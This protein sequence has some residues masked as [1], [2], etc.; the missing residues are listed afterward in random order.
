MSDLQ[1]FID[2]FRNKRVFVI[3]D[4]IIDH[5]IHG[6]VS[7]ISPD[8]PVPLVE[9]SREEHF[10][11]AL[12]KVIQY[13]LNFGGD[14]EAISCVG[15]DYEGEKFQQEIAELN[16]GIKG[17]FTLGQITPKITRVMSK[18][19][20]L[21]RLE[22][23]YNFTHQEENVLGESIVNF[24]KERAGRA[25]VILILDYDLGLLDPPIIEKVLNIAN[26][27]KKKI[28]V[29][30]AST[31]F[32]HYQ[33]VE[34][35]HLNRDVA[36]ASLNMN[37]LNETAIRIV[38][39]KILNTTRCN[40]L[41]VPWIEGD[42]YYFEKNHVNVFPTMVNEAS[43]H[44]MNVS[45]ASIAAMSLMAASSAPGELSA[46]VAHLAGSLAARKEIDD[47]FTADELKMMVENEVSTTS[48]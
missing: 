18:D 26:Q 12:K 13:I 11:G 23:K 35:M 41:Y 29:R 20:Q 1:D 19:Q 36:S 6:T 9:I 28:V 47:F 22:K 38:G 25:D 21:L 16:V 46:K 2:N 48:Q 24:L 10:S 14:A 40:G 32:E 39:T 44:F 42:S 15:K 8:A 30:P 7:A 27:N 33:R 31:K 3:G 34:M 5:Y 45:S 43:R 37:L 17:I 4:A